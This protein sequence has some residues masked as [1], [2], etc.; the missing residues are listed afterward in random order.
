MEVR[1]HPCTIPLYLPL[2]E[3]I[4]DSQSAVLSCSR[5]QK[6]APA[7]IM[8]DVSIFCLN[9]YYMNDK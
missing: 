4:L 8:A 7:K 2:L 1:H 5:F 6:T 9:G 3:T